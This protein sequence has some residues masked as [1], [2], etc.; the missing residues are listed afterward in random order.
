MRDITERMVRV[1]CTARV[2]TD[3]GHCQDFYVKFLTAS[4]TSMA[5]ILETI[6]C[7][8]EWDSGLDVQELDEED[9]HIEPIALDTR[10]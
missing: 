1:T 3:E 2:C 6:R 10:A 8:A 5:D 9:V 7:W 4:D